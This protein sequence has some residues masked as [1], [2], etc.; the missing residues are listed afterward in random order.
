MKRA[1]LY[2]CYI[3]EFD[4][5]TDV[6]QVSKEA[7]RKGILSMRASE[8]RA[9]GLSL[10]F[11]L[12][13]VFAIV[14]TFASQ[15]AASAASPKHTK[16]VPNVVEVR[17][18]GGS[19][20]FNDTC[21][22]TGASGCGVSFSGTLGGSLSA[23]VGTGTISMPVLNGTAQTA[24]FSFPTTIAD[25]RGVGGWT[26][27]ASSPGLTVNT[28]SGP[29]TVPFVLGTVSAACTAG[30]PASCTGPTDVTTTTGSLASTASTYASASVAAGDFGTTTVLVTGSVSLGADTLGGSYSGTITVIAAPAI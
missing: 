1:E 18:P 22:A 19:A 13:A 16:L 7:M 23:S 4:V 10:T 17:R 28:L 9:F 12:T 30:A 2:S 20:G 3:V 25:T 5:F 27:S 26:L 15:G 11:L 8:K 21:D 14:T 6:H 29:T 24:I